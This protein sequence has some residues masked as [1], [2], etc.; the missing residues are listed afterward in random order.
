M[1][2][3]ARPDMSEAPET[4]GTSTNAPSD[5]IRSPRA[6]MTLC[7]NLCSLY[8]LGASHRALKM[9]GSLEHTFAKWLLQVMW[10]LRHA[11]PRGEGSRRIPSSGAFLAKHTRDP[12]TGALGMAWASL[13]ASRVPLRITE[14]SAALGALCVG[15]LALG[16]PR[17]WLARSPQ[18]SIIHQDAQADQGWAS[19]PTGLEHRHAGLRAGH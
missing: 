18:P 2:P 5:Y 11:E 6:E 9:A 14:I 8:L 7:F 15:F 13:R 16:P 19:V 1:V 3:C 10:V 12:E 17:L 4:A